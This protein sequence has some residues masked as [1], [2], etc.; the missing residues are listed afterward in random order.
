MSLCPPAPAECHGAPLA[1]AGLSPS[2]R[3][4]QQA[5]RLMAQTPTSAC[6]NQPAQVQQQNP[7]RTWECA[8]REMGEQ[9][10]RQSRWQEVGEETKEAL[11]WREGGSVGHQRQRA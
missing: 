2:V 11:A 6:R 5:L 9:E 4:E 3:G 8:N 7:R 1:A 10:R